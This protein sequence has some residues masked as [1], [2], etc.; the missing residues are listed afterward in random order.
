MTFPSFSRIVYAGIAS[1]MPAL[2]RV[3]L[4]SDAYFVTCTGLREGILACEK[5]NRRGEYNNDR[6]FDF[7]D[8]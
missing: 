1:G 4:L 8:S 2:I 3:W 7:L 6:P 5:E